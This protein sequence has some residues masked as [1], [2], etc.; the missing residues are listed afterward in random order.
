MQKIL[1]IAISVPAA[2]VLTV[3]IGLFIADHVAACRAAATD[4]RRVESL[5]Q[6][7]RKDMAH[8]AA[9]AAELDRQTKA[10]LECSERRKSRTAVLIVAAVVFLLGAKWLV[11]LRR[12]APPALDL[13]AA[14]RVSGPGFRVSGI[15]KV[16]TTPET[17]NRAPNTPNRA[18][19]AVGDDL[20][21]SFLDGVIAEHGRQPAAAVPILQ[22]I[23]ARYHYLPDAALKRL[24]ELT[25][26][27]PAQIAG[28]STF[29]AQFRRSPA[30]RHTIKVCHGTACHV[31]GAQRLTDE[32]RRH[33]QIDRDADTD[34]QRMFTVDP[35]ACLGCCSLAPVMM[36]DEKTVG[37]LT[38]RRAWEAI[39]ACRR[40]EP[41]A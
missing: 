19:S 7:A 32:I 9:L 16:P 37:R 41:S 34:P 14:A 18:C 17:R 23:Q 26:I 33:L 8:A 6:A 36:I 13:I 10:S 25:A 1:A 21:L 12:P 31:A 27:T 24:C 40:E 3:C 15:E 29:Y 28:V 20:D 35:V 2:V 4:K 22:A 39:E 11:S 38:P 30:G 5:R